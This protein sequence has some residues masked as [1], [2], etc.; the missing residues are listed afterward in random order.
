[1]NKLFFILAAAMM[2]AFVSCERSTAVSPIKG[3]WKSDTTN[4]SMT[5]TFTEKN[6]EFTQNIES[7]NA[8]ATYFG[9][10]TISDKIISLNFDSIKAPKVTHPIVEYIAPEQMPTEAIL[11]G[12]STIAYLKFIFKRDISI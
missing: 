8:Q 1:M 3:V 10:Y 4:M 9:T 12:D 11:C 5:L 2:F 6:V 7:F